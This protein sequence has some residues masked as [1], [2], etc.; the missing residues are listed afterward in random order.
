MKQ[1]SIPFAGVVQKTILVVLC[2]FL[3]SFRGYA[4]I[5]NID[6]R[7]EPQYECIYSYIINE[8]IQETYTTVLQIGK[9]F[10]RFYD[11]TAY[12]VDSLSYVP[13]FS[14]EQMSK[15]TVLRRTSMFYFDSEIW[16]NLPADMMTVIMEVSPNRMS[17]QEGMGEMKW[18]LEDG[19]ATICGYSCSKASTIYGGRKW[20]VWYAP[21]IPSPAGPWKFN[22]LPGLILAASD[23]ESKHEFRAITFRKGVTPVVKTN[24]VTIFAST[25][26]KTLSAKSMSEKEIASGKMP[27]VSEVR[28]VSIIKTRDGN[29]IIYINGVAR[30]PRPNGYQPLELE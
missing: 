29:S 17:Y 1:I 2:V 22:G 14:E 9:E 24:D 30:R 3:L 19:I 5:G 12:M 4:Q 25:R 23:Q 16:Q 28:D 11:Y 10:C 26:E 7:C 27:S 15:Y 21:D 8:G 18:V 6:S 20:T 13:D